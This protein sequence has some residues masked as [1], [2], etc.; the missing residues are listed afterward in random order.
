MEAITKVNGVKEHTTDQGYTTILKVRHIKGNG[1]MGLDMVLAESSTWMET[2]IKVS[3]SLGLSMARE[4]TYTL[5][6]TDTKGN[7]ITIGN[8]GTEHW[9]SEMEIAIREAGRGICFME[10]EFIDLKGG[11][12]WKASL[13]MVDLNHLQHSF[14]NNS[15]AGTNQQQ[16]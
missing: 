16:N 12:N 7:T 10:T 5:R 4:I 1:K 2:N 9:P 6:V 3:L 15:L 13:K 14:N 8:R 11:I